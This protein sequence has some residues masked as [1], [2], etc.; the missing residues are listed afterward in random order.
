MVGNHSD[1]PDGCIDRRTLLR[2]TAAAGVAALG[3]GTMGSAAAFSGDD[4]DITGP[5]D[6]PRATTRGHFDISWWDDVDLT[7]GHT[8][9]DYQTVGDIPGWN[10]AAPDEVVISVHGWKTTEDSAPDHFATVSHSLSRNGYDAPVVG[11]SYDADTSTTDWWPAVE[12]A[13]RNGPKLAHFLAD[14]AA[15]APDTTFRIV[16]HSLGATVTC[17]TIKALNSWGYRDLL[18]SGTLLGGAVD[19]DAVSTEG[20]FGDDIAAAVG[21]FDNFWKSDDDVLNWAYTTG[22]FDSAAGEEGCE[23][24]EPWNYTDHNVDYVPDHFSYHEPGD[25]CM[26]EVV[27]AW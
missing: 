27:A 11:F 23:G 13:E 10:D 20:E 26:P 14:Y 22:E 5:A 24:P 25:G 6:F 1:R 12:I 15:R 3:V 21:Q 8:A 7:D 4:G 2:S 17:E 16:G 19:N 18:A 9:Y